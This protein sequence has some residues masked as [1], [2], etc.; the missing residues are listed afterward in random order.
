MHLD[1]KVTQHS[2]GKFALTKYAAQHWFKHACF[3]GV[4]EN[5]DEGMKQL[6]N[7]RKPHFG[8]WLWIYDP[9]V[10]FWKQDEL[11]QAK[12]PQ[13]PHRM[14]LHYVAFCGLHKVVK[15]LVIEH[16]EDVNSWSFNNES[17]PLHLTSQDRHVDITQFLIKHGTDMAAQ[18]KYGSTVLHEASSRGHLD[19]TWFLIEHSTNA[20]A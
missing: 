14:A 13:P 12:W 6:L 9:T 10:P 8:I 7:K 11:E 18:N 4:W 2:L 15:V 3:E 1:E 16:S 19:L 5:A 20:A 17:M